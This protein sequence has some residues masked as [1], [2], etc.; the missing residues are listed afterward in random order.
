MKKR[1]SNERFQYTEVDAKDDC[2]D[3]STFHKE[4]NDDNDPVLKSMFSMTYDEVKVFLKSLQ[5]FVDLSQ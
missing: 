4:D 5:A 1:I 3:F 2:I